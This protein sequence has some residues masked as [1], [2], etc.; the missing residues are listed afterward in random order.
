V[1]I[2]PSN[3]LGPQ[4]S[5]SVGGAESSAHARTSKTSNESSSH[6]SDQ[7]SLSSDA[8][9]LSSLRTQLNS[10]PEIRQDRVA[11]ISAALQNGT[12]SVSNKQI[13]QSLLRDFQTSSSS[14][15]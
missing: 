9:R 13:A 4:S 12:Y 3:L 11:T 10:V 5:T 2:D 6:S 1:K 15:K 8:V 7:A 14:G